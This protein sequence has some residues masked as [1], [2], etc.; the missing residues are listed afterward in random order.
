MARSGHGSPPRPT[1]PCWLGA[2][3]PPSSP[4]RR[5]RPSTLETTMTTPGAHLATVDLPDFGR[6][7]ATPELPASRYAERLEALRVRMAEHHF[8]RLVVYA[9][10]EHSANLSF[11]TGFDPRF[12]EAILIVGR[13]GDP[14][15]LVGNECGG[16]AGAA[17]RPMRRHLHQDLSRPSQPR[18]RSRPLDDV[19]GDEGIGRGTRVGVVGWK[20]YADP[21][22]I[23]V[24]AFLVD[25]LRARTADPALVRNAGDLLISPADGL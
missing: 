13:S 22:T 9:D 21:A 5:D 15:I 10:R 20:T 7:T 8:D 3:P 18:D 4:R 12:E 23:E 16:T 25:A 11:L 19:L 24:P 2:T 1:R 14:A 17:P 6:P